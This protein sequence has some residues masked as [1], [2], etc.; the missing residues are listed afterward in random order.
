[1]EIAPPKVC[2]NSATSSNASDSIFLGDN[3]TVF[4]L[5]IEY[6]GRS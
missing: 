3:P 6:E 2:I 1:M 4:S 5:S